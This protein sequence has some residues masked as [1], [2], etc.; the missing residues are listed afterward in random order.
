MHVVFVDR[1]GAK[2]IWELMGHI[3]KGL[4]GH[5]NQVTFV[6]WD[7]GRQVYSRDIPDGVE[8]L[9]IKVPPKKNI[10]DLVHQ[11]LIFA[12]EFRKLMHRIKPDI[13]HCNFAV[14]S[15]VA[16][17]T[18]SREGVPV[19]LST[20]H[21]LYDSMHS[22]YRWGLRF[23][24]RYCTAVIYVSQAVASSFGRNAVLVNEISSESKII[25]VVIPNGVD[26]YKIRT[27]IEGIDKRV[28]G[29]IVCVGRM[30]PIKG[31][32]LLI[33]ALPKVIS[34]YPD[35]CIRLIGSGPMEYTLQRRVK[36]LGLSNNV[37]FLGWLNHDE[38]LREIASAELVVVPSNQE[39]FGLIVAEALICG[40][41]LLVSDIP[42]FRE[43]L[44]GIEDDSRYF[45]SG[46]IDD[47]SN[48]MAE[49]LFVRTEGKVLAKDLPES[50]QNRISADAMVDSY[51]QLYQTLITR[52]N[53]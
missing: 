29:R 34:L 16:R 39:G 40:T 48:K 1:A 51:I 28:K 22:H 42:S 18:A 3:A 25:H 12:R 26:N 38:V 7:D 4:I 9:Y 14:P 49:F 2:S 47:L 17:W 44:E 27:A 21:E 35:L 52:V 36:E 20:Q 13:V 50:V 31:Q 15:I 10:L 30:M 24:E 6:M 53:G 45:E 46:N 37:I 43:L 32:Q 41:Q 5:G 33:E 19:I 23:T 11:H 8:V